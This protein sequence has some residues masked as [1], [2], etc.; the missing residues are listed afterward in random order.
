MTESRVF[1]DDNNHRDAETMADDTVFARYL[2]TW[3]FNTHPL[4][5]QCIM[6]DANTELLEQYVI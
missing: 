6:H 5:A 1:D 2:K 4:Q 3:L